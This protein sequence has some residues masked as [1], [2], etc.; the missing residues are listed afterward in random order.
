VP[1]DCPG[2]DTGC[3]TRTCVSGVC[4]VANAPAGTP[5]AAQVAGDCHR[6]Q[7][8]GNGDAFSAVDDGD[9]PEDGNACTQDLCAAGVPSNPPAPPHAPCPSGVCDG[10]GACVG[11]VDGADCAS[12][13]CTGNVCQAPTCSDGVRNGSETGV[14][15][16]GSCPACA[17][18]TC[19][20]DVDCASG[21][22]FASRCQADLN[23]CTPAGA[24]DLTGS[25]AAAVAFP[26]AGFAYSPRCIK[27]KV[28]TVVTFSGDFAFHPLQGGAVLGGVPTAATSGPFV[29]V[30]STGTTAAFAMGAAGNYPYFCTVHATLGMTGAVFAVP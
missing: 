27:V 28:G 12:A 4:G 22:C 3:H 25:A 7:C 5:L 23:G 11:C 9:V 13:V 24:T 8:D 18:S 29:T 21:M 6:N 16:G 10:A 15:C 2:T 26:G 19:A 20:A 17:G 14:D 1:A 30:T